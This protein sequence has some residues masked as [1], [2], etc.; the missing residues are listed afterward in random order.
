MTKTFTT[1]CKFTDHWNY[2]T[3][4]KVIIAIWKTS[5]DFWNQLPWNFHYAKFYAKL[6]LLKFRKKITLFGYLWTGIW[7][8]HC[9]IWNQYTR[10]KAKF[11]AKMKILKFRATHTRSFG[12]EFDNT[13]AIFEISLIP[14]W[15]KKN[16]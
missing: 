11:R 5:C 12:L 14:K 15:N 6:I 16:K 13:I 1:L 2:E 3:V 8:N 7:N 9:H 10:I 4:D